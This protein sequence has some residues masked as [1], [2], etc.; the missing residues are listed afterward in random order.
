MAD[1][2]YILKVTT[3]WT[4]RDVSNIFYDFFEKTNKSHFFFQNFAFFSNITYFYILIIVNQFFIIFNF[5]HDRFEL[6]IIL[7]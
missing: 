5:L 3:G 2:R 7:F 6:T 4:G 1:F